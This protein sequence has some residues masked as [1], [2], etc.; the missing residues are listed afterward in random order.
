LDYSRLDG[1]RCRRTVIALGTSA[2]PLAHDHREHVTD[3]DQLWRRSVVIE[4]C[5]AKS[6]VAIDGRGIHS[7]LN[8]VRRTD[9]HPAAEFWFCMF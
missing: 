1:A 7:C 4:P 2:I 6:L 5:Y 8:A 9:G 3:E